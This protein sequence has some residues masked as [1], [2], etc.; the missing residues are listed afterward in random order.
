M[1]NTPFF[2]LGSVR[3]GTTLL[4]DILR[5]HPRLECPEETHFFRWSDPFGTP[6]YQRHYIGSK[7]F[8]SHRELDGIENFEFH[9]TLKHTASR[10]SMMD[11][12]GKTALERRDNIK[13]RWFDKTP[14]NVYGILLLSEMYPEAKFIHIHRNP[15]NVVASL[16][17]GAVMPEHDMRAAINSWIEAVA[18]INQ[19][20]QLA[21]QRL[22]E[23]G[24]ET[25]VDQPEE[26]VANMLEFLGEAAD[27]I[28]SK[29][30]KT[31]KE[32]NKYKNKLT[33]EQIAYVLGATEKY[34]NI[35]G[36]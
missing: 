10:Q 16:M 5:M 26:Q 14:Q 15:L 19:Y 31:H 3:S 13:G 8:Q 23:V 1:D 9:Y 17:E 6:R 35:Y 2:I 7:L 28:P 11:W 33:E 25:L 32:K 36:Y 27:L 18:I 22:W 24:Y 29:A 20:K 34:R 30:F 21:P 12:Y 4:R